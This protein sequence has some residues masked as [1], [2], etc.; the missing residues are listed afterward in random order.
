MI[1]PGGIMSIENLPFFAL[2]LPHVVSRGLLLSPLET[3]ILLRLTAFSI[4]GLFLT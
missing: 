1:P 3:R 4:L 2:T